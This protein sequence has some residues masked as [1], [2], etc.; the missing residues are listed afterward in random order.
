MHASR[1][2]R[3]RL[4]VWGVLVALLLSSALLGRLD[5]TEHRWLTLWP[6][7]VA[8][9]LVFIFRSAFVGLLVGAVCGSLLIQGHLLDAVVGLVAG[10]LLPV[11]Q[12][13]WKLSAIAFT[14]ILGG[15]VAL[16]EAGGGLQ[17]LVRRMLGSARAPVEAD[18]V[19][20]F[21]FWNVGLF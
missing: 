8:L 13:P 5:G 3:N 4:P 2:N 12:S 17:A 19:D 11:F 6:S 21:W 1:R 16:V 15:F 7:A 9:V 18:A 10:D 20:G 14:L